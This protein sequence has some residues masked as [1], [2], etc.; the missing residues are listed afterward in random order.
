MR[1]KLSVFV[2]AVCLLT[3]IPAYGAEFHVSP[4]GNDN[5]PGDVA[6]AV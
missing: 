3:V 5:S 2:A 1:Q 4:Q 6:E